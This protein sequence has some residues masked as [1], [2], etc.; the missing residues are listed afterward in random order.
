ME[1]G[2]G[3]RALHVSDCQ[4]LTTALYPSGGGW[5]LRWWRM[6]VSQTVRRSWVNLHQGRDSSGETRK[7]MTFVLAGQAFLI[8]PFGDQPLSRAHNLEI[9]LWPSL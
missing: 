9:L 7:G 6:W 5:A 1:R 8:C 2:G 4:Q 3:G